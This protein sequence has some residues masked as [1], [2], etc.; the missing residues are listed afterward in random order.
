M[1]AEEADTPEGGPFKEVTQGLRWVAI[2]GVIDH[3]TMLANYL[4]AL[5]NPTIQPNYKQLNVERQAKQSDGSWSDWE[6]VDSEKNHEIVYN[7]PEEEEELT[8]ETVRI[9]QLVDPLPFLKAG[10]WERVHV[11]S[12]VPKE[13]L[14]ASPTSTAMGGSDMPMM[15]PPMPPPM[16]GGEGMGMPMMMGGSAGGGANENTNYPKTD[17][18]TIMIRSLDFTVE[19][20]TTY[21]FR[22]QI[23][24]YNPNYQHEDVNPGVNTK[25]L[26]LKGPWS[27]PTNEVTMP[28]DVTAY[29]MRKTPT[30]PNAK[31]TDSVSFQV[32]KWNPENGVTTYRNM[33]FSLGQI[34]GEIRSTKIPTTDGT[35]AKSIPVDYNSHQLL[36]DETGGEQP[37]SQYGVGGKLDVP[38]LSLLLRPDGSVMVRNEA[39][40]VV[41]TVRKDMKSNYDREIEESGKKRESSNGMA[42]SSGTR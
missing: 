18:A 9:A 1:K 10:Y 36:I 8:P 37:L 27:E 7:L 17:A 21:R 19:P 28:D 33:D 6:A 16:S 41:D 24:V 26:E 11:A 31:R 32:V 15:A 5:K 14:D 35:E 22:V 25:D 4:T 29:A 13:K 39:F 40:D 12:L 2:T 20:D 38:A 42:P 34:V 23:V 30:G 3:K